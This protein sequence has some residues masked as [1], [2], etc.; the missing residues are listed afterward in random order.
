MASVTLDGLV[1][2]GPDGNIGDK[3]GADIL[4]AQLESQWQW[5][6]EVT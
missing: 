1:V 4:F 5:G 3:D 2:K 6:P